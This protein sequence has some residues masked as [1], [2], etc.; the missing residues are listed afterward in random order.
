MT[1]KLLFIATFIITYV[2]FVYLYL[3]HI[4]LSSFDNK[5]RDEM[6][7]LRGEINTTNKVVIVDIDE[8][9]LKALG[10]W[11]WS[12]DVVSKIIVNLTN[13]D[14]LI[15]GLDMFFSEKD[16]KSE[17][18]LAKKYHL[19]IKD[20]EDN[21]KIFAYVLANTPT[22]LGFFFNFDD[23]YTKNIFPNIPAIFIE[24]HKKENFLLQAKGYISNIPILENN[25]YSSGFINTIPDN[26]GVVRSVPLLVEYDGMIYPSLGFEMYRIATGHKK[27]VINYSPAGIDDIVLGKQIIKT[28]RFGRLFI[29]YRGDEKRFK[30]ISAIDIY[31]NK[32]D[33]NSIKDKF[34]LI[35]TSAA[36][37]FDLRSTP[38]NNVY[39][40]V[41]VHANLIDNLLKGDFLFKPNT[42]ELIDMFDLFIIGLA[43]LFVYYFFDALI[44]IV[45]IFLFNI[46]YFF[47]IYFVMFKYGYIINI[48]LPMV[49]SIVL[50]VIFNAINYFLESKKNRMLKH[51]FAKKVSSGVM[52]EL[53]N[54]KG[55]ILAPKEKEIT[56]FFSDIRSFTTISEK[57][58]D[59]NK[60]I[61]LLNIYMTP[62]VDNINKHK[63]TIDKFIGDAI[64]AY[65]NAP[66][67]IKN[68]ADEAV[69]SAIEQIKILR[70]LDNKIKQKFG[71]EIDIGIGINSGIATI[72]EMGSI[73]RSDFTV[74]GDNVNLASRL[75]GLNK[76][77]HTNI[78]ITENTKNLL[79]NKYI[80][81]EVDIVKVKGKSEAIKIYQVL[82]FG[83]SNQFE[84]YYQALN[85][86]RNSEFNEA[87]KLFEKLFIQTDDKLYQVYIKRCDYFIENP[88]SN[89][90]GVWTFHT[91]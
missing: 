68:H 62:M 75:E 82:D 45:F 12:R 15:I 72:G 32:F 83:D 90:D 5:L 39:P 43:V 3:F 29:N 7:L 49:E 35:G 89:F 38:Y 88:P 64:M 65:W 21:D 14:A 85:L 33:K 40:G 41:E 71:L 17:N 18:Y 91:K 9:S 23:N 56:I 6:F 36:G 30:Y 28:D 44:S 66:I 26:D 8:K 20:A 78:L 47:V 84:E 25:A 69:S 54:N 51:I 67:D 73:G 10:Q 61:E 79:V 53:I 31:D 46:L 2:F 63:G 27:V 57:L 24:K 52:E 58:N 76:V 70:N 80:L 11:P 34:V 60:V 55:N 19:H 1:K 42:K 59:P 22:I 13:A 77:Y 50:A 4:N 48:F 74:I 86:Y 87:K 16:T 37:L 81:R